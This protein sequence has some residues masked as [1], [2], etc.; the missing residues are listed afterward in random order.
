M[1]QANR[2]SLYA[3]TISH[4]QP[5]QIGYLVLRR[6]L[7][8]GANLKEKVPAA[9]SRPG[10]ALRTAALPS[11][12]QTTGG[13]GYGEFRFLNVSKALGHGG[14][15]WAS[16]E[17]TKLWR[18]NL[19]YFDYILDSWRPPDNIADLISNWVRNN[20]VGSGTGWEPY[21]TSLRIVNWIK[22]FLREDF[23]GR[24]TTAWL[25]SLYRQA[26]WLE[27]N[28][29]YHILANHLLKNAKALF[30]AGTF[31]TGA[32]AERWRRK[33]WKI[34][35]EQADEQILSDGGHFERSPMYH[36]IVIEDYLDSLNLV[37]GT[38]GLVSAAEADFLAS[39]TKRALDFLHDICRPDGSIPLFNDSAAGIAPPLDALAEYAALVMGY[40]RS[41]RT[42]GLRVSSR[43]ASG[44]F[45]IRNDG[46]MLVVDCGELGPSYQPGHAHCDTLSFELTSDGR[47]LIVD[48]GV[49]DYEDSEMR[50][51]VRSTR[52]HNTAMIDG[53]EQSEL[54]GIFR[55]ARRA[56]PMDA[57]IEKIGESKARFSGSHDGFAR[58]PGRPVHARDIEYEAEGV[59]TV[60]D[61]FTGAGEHRLESFIHLHPDFAVR[62]EGRTFLIAGP[63]ERVAAELEVLAGSEIALET[64]WYCPEF[65]KRQENAVIRLFSS[66]A[67]PRSL[68]YRIVKRRNKGH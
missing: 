16:P 52:A 50:R 49:Y 44:Y 64:G 23:R 24:V 31:F 36:S 7:P 9:Q 30:F 26:Q 43:D 5:R 21:P 19:H 54:W 29:E 60:V 3:R 38:A 62:Q 41:T 28:I 34:L 2:L 57:K 8:R 59:W 13:G 35:L 55:V 58:L 40:E 46:D 61:H 27:K 32:N 56:R 68:G 4:L 67:L 14:V 47:P 10:V 6:V 42:E 12:M 48:S 1:G 45:V 17:M 18:Y 33:G 22:L 15:D 37:G 39:K 25:D 20:P 66:G 11:A 63:N 53:C 65:G 51:Y